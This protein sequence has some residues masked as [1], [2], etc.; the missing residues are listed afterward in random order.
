[1]I[2]ASFPDIQNVG[3]GGSLGD[4]VQYNQQMKGGHLACSRNARTQVEVPCDD[5]RAYLA[6]DKHGAQRR[7]E[8]DLSV[9]EFACA[10]PKSS[11]T[12]GR[13][14]VCTRAAVCRSDMYPLAQAAMN[15]RALWLQWAQQEVSF[16][17]RQDQCQSLKQGQALKAQEVKAGD[18]TAGSEEP[19]AGQKQLSKWL[20]MWSARRKATGSTASSANGRKNSR[21]GGG[22]AASRIRRSSSQ[23]STKKIARVKS[24]RRG[25]VVSDEDS[26]SDDYEFDEADGEG[27]DSQ[28]EEDDEEGCWDSEVELVDS[29]SDSEALSRSAR[30]NGRRWDTVYTCSV[31]HYCDIYSWRFVHDCRRDSGSRKSMVAIGA[32]GQAEQAGGGCDDDGTETLTNVLVLQGPSGC[33][34]SAAVHESARALGFKVI[35][36]NTSQ[37]R[38]GAAIKKLIAEAAQSA[39]IMDN[40]GG[41]AAGG[42]GLNLS[43]TTATDMNLILFDEVQSFA[44]LCLALCNF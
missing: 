14:L 31:P 5:L 30:N 29:A 38:N 32:L 42:S 2:Q 17:Q 18:D 34:K 35:E 24:S 1:M 19:T 16:W 25:R 11:S 37:A 44:F 33:G 8:A 21:G 15:L 13:Q 3:L 22:G 20:R 39:H 7:Q 6:I 9:L 23:A 41:A 28:D 40:L 27:E 12:G 26:D 4:I 10:F 43:T 36:V